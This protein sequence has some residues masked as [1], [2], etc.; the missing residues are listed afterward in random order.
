MTPA[1]STRRIGAETSET[2]ALILEQA[3]RLMLEEG[4]AAVTYRKVAAV[5]DVTA[6][7]VQY[8]FPTIDDLFI[9]LLRQ[10]AEPNLER[11]TKELE[12]H[13]EDPLR[14]IWDYSSDE[15]TAA[16]M[17]EF[18]SLGNHRKAIRAE[19]AELSA[20]SKTVQVEALSKLDV[21]FT[22]G[23]RGL[24][25]AALLF[26][27][28]GIPKILLLESALGVSTGHAEILDVVEGSLSDAGSHPKT[29][30]TS[31]G[32]TNGR[33]AHVKSSGPRAQDG[34]AKPTGSKRSKTTTKGGSSKARRGT[35]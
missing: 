21:S 12:L 8:Y 15:T 7:L 29:R 18:M 30:G 24:P 10:H 26:L 31:K 13:S 4:Y 17:M 28:A 22:L 3:E 25:S 11:L 19:V 27:L 1:K 32:P 34:R 5:A 20:K 33:G 9:A 6:P 14:V 35:S 2:R 16:L 23:D